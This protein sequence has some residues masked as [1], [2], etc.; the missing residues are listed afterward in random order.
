MEEKL[1]QYK[2]EDFKQF[3][4]KSVNTNLEVIGVRMKY[5]RE[6]AKEEVK[7]GGWEGYITNTKPKYFEE[8][9]LQGIIVATAKY[10]S[11][12]ELIKYFNI[13]LPRIDSWASC[14]TFCNSFKSIAKHKEQF[15]LKIDQLITSD[16]MWHR[17]VGFVMLLCYY[18]DSEY[19]KMIFDYITKYDNQDEYYVSMSVAWLLSFICVKYPDQCVEYLQSNK[20][21]IKTTRR[22]IQK[23]KD[24]FRIKD[25]ENIISK[26]SF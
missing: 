9:V 19:L 4:K 26:I 17:R 10:E 15:K 13:Y 22:T 12:E 11:Y 24:S 2:E 21:G 1:K 25:K 23:I 3:H 8:V 20:L 16:N 7:K 14:D 5:I 6:I 18:I